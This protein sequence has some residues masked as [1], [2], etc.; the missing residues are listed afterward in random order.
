MFVSMI[1]LMITL[2]FLGSPVHHCRQL[3]TNTLSTANLVSIAVFLTVIS[4]VW[5]PCSVVI[6]ICYVWVFVL[7]LCRSLHS[8]ACLTKKMLFLP[9]LQLLVVLIL[10]ALPL[11]LSFAVVILTTSHLP[12]FT[13]VLLVN[14][15]GL[16]MDLSGLVYPV[17]LLF[18]NHRIRED[19]KTQMSLICGV[20][21][22]CLRSIYCKRCPGTPPAQIYPTQDSAQL[23]ETA[24]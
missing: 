21:L 13:A 4:S 24:L 6:G 2:F 7:Y 16:Y 20:V 1:L 18:L 22:N 8:D 15:S 11:S 3:C 9:V 23:E 10:V 14:V 5:I 17:L 19:W 12:R